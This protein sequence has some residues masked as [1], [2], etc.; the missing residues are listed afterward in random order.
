[1]GGVDPPKHKFRLL[2]KP[3]VTIVEKIGKYCKRP[4]ER[5]FCPPLGQRSSCGTVGSAN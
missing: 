1:M 5:N 2:S 3:K 4:P